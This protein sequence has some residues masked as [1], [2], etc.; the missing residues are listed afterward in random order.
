MKPS[1]I[2]S[3]DNIWDHV[4]ADGFIAVSLEG[5]KNVPVIGKVLAK[6]KDAVE[7]LLEGFVEREMATLVSCEWRTMD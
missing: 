3:V 2:V 6:E 1:G 7:P 5:Y 4:A